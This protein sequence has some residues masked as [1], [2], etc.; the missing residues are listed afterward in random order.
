MV[1]VLMKKTR[2]NNT[3]TCCVN[4]I[5]LSN[6][7]NI[8]MEQIK[9]ACHQKI[10]K[11]IQ[12]DEV[13]KDPVLPATSPVLPVTSPV[14]PGTSPMTDMVTTDIVSATPGPPVWKKYAL[15][16]GVGVGVLLLIILLIIFL[17]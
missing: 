13:S 12:A 11:I 9:Q 2:N 8:D 7:T 6:A 5:D 1:V 14:L 3:N 10:V 15:T 4:S 17:L 16:V